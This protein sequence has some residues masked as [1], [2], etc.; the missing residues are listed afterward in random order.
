MNNTVYGKTMENMRKRVKLRAI[1][2][3]QD[4]NIHQDLH[5]LIGKYLKT[6]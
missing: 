4:L 3:S 1:K 6:I 5:T 2:N